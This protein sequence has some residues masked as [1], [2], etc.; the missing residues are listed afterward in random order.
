MINDLELISMVMQYKGPFACAYISKA[1]DHKSW[2]DNLYIS[3]PC[4]SLIS[5]GTVEIIGNIDDHSHNFVENF[6]DHLAMAVKLISNL[7]FVRNN[8][9][10][11]DHYN[12]VWS[13]DA[14]KRYY[15]LTGIEMQLILTEFRQLINRS[16]INSIFNNE[17][18]CM[19]NNMFDKL[20]NV[21]R[22]SKSKPSKHFFVKM[23]D[24]NIAS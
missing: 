17:Y 7:S 20:V 1:I 9:D 19:I 13:K 16:A 21:M 15:D 8:N 24:K 6:S 10:K 5:V 11:F 18:V 23:R 3:K 12:Y 14:G 22:E 4:F 2:L